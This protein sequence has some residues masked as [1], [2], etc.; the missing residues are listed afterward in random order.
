MKRIHSRAVAGLVAC[1]TCLGCSD[2]WQAETHPASGRVSIN[3]EPPTGALVQLYP[4][5]E[6]VD[7][8][9]S[10]PWG[11]VGDDG[12]FSLSTYETAD[13]APAGEYSFTIVWP[14]D[15][16]VPAPT[17]RLQ[18]KY[19]QPERSK[20]PVTIQAGENVLP[21]VEITGA[22]VL[23]KNQASAP[24]QAPPGPAIGT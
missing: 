13:G 11:K 10:R 18:F 16:S 23:S 2:N 17:D 20:W 5:G 8:R 15:P 3:G 12:A 22:K 7:V 14:V 1:L 24:R 4:V 9:N 19:S 21:L 6:K